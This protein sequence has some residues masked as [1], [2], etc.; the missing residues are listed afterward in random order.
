MF[1]NGTT[2]AILKAPANTSAVNGNLSAAN[3]KYFTAD[4]GRTTSFPT[5]LGTFTA[6]SGADWFAIF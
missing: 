4:T 6:R 5:T 2:A 1:Q 3:S